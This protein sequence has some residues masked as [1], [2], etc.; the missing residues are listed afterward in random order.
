M[1]PH[2]QLLRYR[3]FRFRPTFLAVFLAAVFLSLPG[4]VEREVSLQE[5]E[6]PKVV[7]SRPVVLELEDYREYSGRAQAIHNVEVRARVTGY[8]KSVNFVEGDY[9]DPAQRDEP[10]FEIDDRTYVAALEAARAEVERA[11]AVVEK[12]QADFERYK[13][14]FEKN[15]TTQEEYD[16]AKA[17]LAASQAEL[18]GAEAAVETAQ[19]DLDFTRI[20]APVAGRVGQALITEGNLITADRSEGVPLTTIVS[21]A[22]IHVY[23]DVDENTIN[24]VRA[25][26]LAE[27]PSF[28]EEWIHVKEWKIPVY[29]GLSNETGFPHAGYIDFADNT[30]NS[31]TGT[32][33][34]RGLFGNEDRV[35]LPGSFVKVKLIMSQA[36]PRI[37]IPEDAVGTVLTQKYVYVLDADDVAQRRTVKLGSIRAGDNLRVV[38]DGLTADDRIIIEGIQRVQEGRPVDPQ[39]AQIPVP[40]IPK[41]AAALPDSDDAATDANG[42]AASTGEPDAANAPETLDETRGN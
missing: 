34:L 38:E 40:E 16:L 8:L 24:T 20:S 15:A 2:S 4:C 17:A 36:A 35:L 9:I 42:D 7:V 30:V 1:L 21:V 23:F 37:L 14:L 3:E 39:E 33:R 32:L 18:T 27:N 10:L 19:I 11:Q 12:T 13:K 31:E 29:V 22:P 26:R 28:R 6:L 41:P 25:Q 5:P